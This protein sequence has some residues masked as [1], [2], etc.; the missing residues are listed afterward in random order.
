MRWWNLD[1]FST[2]PQRPFA[3]PHNYPNNLFPSS[4]E[5]NADRSN[6]PFGEVDGEPRVYGTCDFE[7]GDTQSGKVAEPSRLSRGPVARAM[8]YMSEVY[9]VNV[10]LPFEALWQW[11]KANPAEAWEVERASR[12]GAETGLSNRWILGN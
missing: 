2:P 8:L 4:G 12:I 11:H 6:H 3:L 1:R 9:G 10:Q 7:V 5:V